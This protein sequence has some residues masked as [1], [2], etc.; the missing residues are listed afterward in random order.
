MTFL[1]SS[2]LSGFWIII[3]I[4]AFIYDCFGIYYFLR[5][6]PSKF[7]SKHIIFQEKTINKF[8]LK[9]KEFNKICPNCGGILQLGVKDGKWYCKNTKKCHYSEYNNITRCHNLNCSN[10]VVSASYL[11]SPFFSNLKD[12]FCEDYNLDKVSCLSLA[13]IYFGNQILVSA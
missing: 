3:L 4:L 8:Y 2:V 6:L 9:L 7:K 11:D 13:Q 10:L 12:V 1:D 5:S